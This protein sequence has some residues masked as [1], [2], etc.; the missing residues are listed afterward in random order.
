MLPPNKRARIA[1]RSTIELVN[2][3]KK[4]VK[5]LSTKDS[6]NAEILV[7]IIK[8]VEWRIP[9]MW[10]TTLEEMLEDIYKYEIP[11]KKKTRDLIQKILTYYDRPNW[12]FRGP[13]VF[14]DIYDDLLFQYGVQR[15]SEKDKKM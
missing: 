1:K 15:D 9:N 12:Q 5:Y 2:L 8:T 3:L 14:G 4:D 6:F 11:L 10:Q 13:D 7:K